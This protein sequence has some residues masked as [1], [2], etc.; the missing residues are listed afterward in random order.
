M[1]FKRK[2]IIILFTA[3]LL[4]QVLVIQPTLSKEVLSE[5]TPLAK[6]S[7]EKPII[8]SLTPD[9]PG[10]TEKIKA[11]VLEDGDC[12]EV[13]SNG[14]PE[15]FYGYGS[16]YTTANH[17]YQDEVH[18]GSY[19]AFYSAKGTEQYSSYLSRSKYMLYISERSYLDEK[20]TMDFWY[21]A[22]ANPDIATGGDIFFYLRISTNLGYYYIYYY[23]SRQ[24]GLPSNQSTYAYFDLRGSLNTWTNIVRNVTEDFEAVFAGPDLSQSYIYY[25]YFVINSPSNPTGD[26]ILLFDDVSITNDTTF[27]YTLNG[28]FEAGNS[29][30]WGDTS[31]GPAS[32]YTTEDDYTQ[33]QRAMN[34]TAFSP[35]STSSS[36]LYAEKYIAIGWNSI[37]K[38][39]IADQPGD[40]T[41]SFDW[42]YSDNPGVG[43]QEAYFYIYSYNGTFESYYQFFL[44]DESDLMLYSNNSGA[45]YASYWFKADGFGS[46]D[47][48]NNF[49]FDYY[50]LASSLGLENLVAYSV[51]YYMICNNAEDAKVQV[52][53]DDF[54]MITHPAGDPSFEG[55][56]QYLPS[57]PIQLWNTPNIPNYANLTTDAHTGNYAAN[58]TANS[59]YVGPYCYRDTFLPVT[60]NQYTDFWWRLDK[61]TNISNPANANIE[62]E[63][64]GSYTIFYVFGNNSYYNPSN[65][66]SN[67]YYFVEG[68]N[69]IG[70]WHNIFRNLSNDA[71]A[72]FGPG[73]YNVTQIQLNAYATGSEEVIALYDDL[74]F[75]RDIE[76]PQFSNLEQTPTDPE[77]GQ[78]VDVSV[79]V[80]DNIMVQWVELVYQID[81]GSWI[82]QF[83]SEVSGKYTSTIPADNYGSIVNYHF[84]ASDVHGHITDLGTSINPYTYVVGDTVDPVMVL[85][86]PLESQVL[87]GTILLEV[88]D[89][90]DVG[91]GLATFE[92]EINGTVVYN[93]LVFP[94]SYSWDTEAFDNTDYPVIFRLEDNA[95]N[96]V[97]IAYDYTVY[98][99][100]TN[101]EAFT[102]FM[103]KW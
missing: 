26:T 90:Y 92:I 66:S 16:A 21:N 18:A 98:N 30:Y 43:S 103:Q 12:E 95:G 6:K 55:Q 10:G 2:T 77:Y 17:S 96:I 102:A 34:M 4:T 25:L 41:F 32:L 76:G 23:L 60:N 68:H 82:S 80:V 27:E 71:I 72:A 85:D 70:T 81:G 93:E 33:G 3:V 97:E 49:H 9:A 62:L 65:S 1:M 31:S 83:M 11:N 100:P 7:L 75:V 59:G 84:I 44:G 94:A 46:R 38:G 19:G 24:S 73:N 74:Y 20:I 35:T 58:L 67:C 101:W 13:K 91:S 78:T 52:L 69:D 61:M 42:K 63:L 48:W 40:L 15:G 28:D 39:Q 57:D 88:T 14:E 22:K 79:D 37:P 45:S 53:V 54:Q 36:Y 51:G 86:V 47:T 89:A 87:I 5:D 50:T 64:G 99:P 56:I 29:N 8:R